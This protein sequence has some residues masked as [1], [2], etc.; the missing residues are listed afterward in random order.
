MIS[1]GYTTKTKMPYLANTGHFL[2]LHFG[3]VSAEVR[4]IFSM[5]AEIEFCKGES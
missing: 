2:L 4:F 1:I 3:N 5:R